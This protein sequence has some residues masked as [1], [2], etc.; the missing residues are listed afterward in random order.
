MGFASGG[1]GCEVYVPISCHLHTLSLR[2]GAVVTVMPK[3]PD[4][5][6][7]TVVFWGFACA[8]NGD[9]EGEAPLMGALGARVSKYLSAKCACRV[10]GLVWKLPGVAET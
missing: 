6:H 1:D 10:V 5:A 3:R 8:L 4:A 9:F 2:H 7:Q